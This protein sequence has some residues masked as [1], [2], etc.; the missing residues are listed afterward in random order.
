MNLEINYSRIS[1]IFALSDCSEDR[2]ILF[3]ILVVYSLH[4]KCA[5]E[6]DINIGIVYVSHSICY[7][8]LFLMLQHCNVYV[9]VYGTSK[10]HVLA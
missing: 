2:E 3:K 8:K 6:N 7:V 10:G 9:Y 5:A 1:Y 4:K